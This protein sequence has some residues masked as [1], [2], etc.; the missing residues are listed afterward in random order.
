MTQYPSSSLNTQ[1][2]LIRPIG[3]YQLHSLIAF[4][5]E[6]LSL[7][8]IHGYLVQI[9]PATDSTRILNPQGTED[10]RDAHGIAVQEG[11]L[12]FTKGNWVYR[13]EWGVW[14]AERVIELPDRAEGI[15]LVGNT[16]YVSCRYLG[17]IFVLSSNTGQRIT[18][19]RAPGVGLENLMVREEDLW[20]CDREE[21]TVYCLDR[22]T[23]K[24]RFSILT[25]F[26]HPTGLVF[27]PVASSTE[28][29]PQLYVLYSS[30]EPYIQDDPNSSDPHRLSI[31]DRCF[32]HPLQFHHN[33]AH[34]FTLSNGYRFE[35]CYVEELAPLDDLNLETVEWRI[36]LPS[37][38]PRQRVLSVEPFGMPFTEEIQEGERVAVFRFDRLQ[39]HDRHIFGWKAVVEGYGVKY[40]LTPQD[41]VP[42][43]ALSPELAERYLIDNENLAMDTPIVQEAA[44][45][46]IGTETNVLRQ[47]LQIRD[48]VYDR[49]SYRIK[50]HIDNP[51]EV[52][53]R[54][55]G[56]CG[57]YVGLLLALCRLN[58]IPCR[59]VG[60]YKCPNYA[61]RMN[62]P[63]YPDYNHVWMEFYLPGMGW[64]PMESN[65]DDMDYG[66]HPLRF[67]GGLAWYH[68][69]IGRGI[70]FERVLVKGVR[71]KELPGE[72]SIGNLAVN[73]VRFKILGEVPPLAS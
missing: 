72:M 27:D 13:C 32:I 38:T 10:L 71:L 16:L 37:E 70:P 69:E 50:P 57:E 64:L 47:V 60:R 46:A 51:D 54:G 42:D 45:E 2:Q 63:L 7:E 22:A 44:K 26:E 43:Q 48:Y 49:L 1:P 52:L 35:L 53:R 67:F 18:Q 23:G 12:W 17:I 20:V 28:T 41:V 9:N 39:H 68:T 11:I 56:S 34:R 19:F 55:T 8:R 21:Q 25:P 36:A 14:V 58:G 62:L 73:H 6:F 15:A 66:P 30:E 31:R 61:D 33:S 59:T 40:H 3:V 5:G 65:P 29:Q 24:L 4:Q